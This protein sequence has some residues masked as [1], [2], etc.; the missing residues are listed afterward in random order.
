MVSVFK[1]CVFGLPNT[2][3]SV[4][5]KLWD[6]IQ[7]MRAW[8]WATF[9]MHK[10]VGGR[11]GNYDNFNW[12]QTLFGEKF[13]YEFGKMIKIWHILKDI[14]LWTIWFERNGKVCNH[15]Q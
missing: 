9:I 1:Q 10:L 6:N 3:E 14:T 7:A 13:P 4:N 11:T 8:R 2:N 5:H 12:K 15:E